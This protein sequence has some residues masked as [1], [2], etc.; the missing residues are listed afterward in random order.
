[1]TSLLSDFELTLDPRWGGSALPDSLKHDLD[2]SLADYL[3]KHPVPPAPPPP[4]V[5]PGYWLAPWITA[6]DLQLGIDT[7]APWFNAGIETSLLAQNEV[8]QHPPTF[9]RPPSA[10]RMIDLIS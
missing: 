8:R 4:P 2:K 1:M 9:G 7:N 6:S 10:P 5:R 3:D